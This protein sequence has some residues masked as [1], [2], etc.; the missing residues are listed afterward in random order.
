ML[1]VL[2]RT[3]S[4]R[5]FFRAHKTYIITDGEENF[6]NFMLKTLVYLLTYVYKIKYN[7][8]STL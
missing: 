7:K 6:D 4:M 3:V 2:K 8:Q 5:R 1:W